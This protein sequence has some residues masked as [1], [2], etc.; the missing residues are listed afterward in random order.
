MFKNMNRYQRG[1]PDKPHPADILPGES[2]H[3]NP[4]LGAPISPE[5]R[6]DRRT[7]AAPAAGQGLLGLH[8]RADHPDHDQSAHGCFGNQPE[9]RS[10]LVGV[11]VAA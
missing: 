4:D 5:R 9:I 11:R 6:Q 2:P 3:L 8:L 7:A 10:S 1:R